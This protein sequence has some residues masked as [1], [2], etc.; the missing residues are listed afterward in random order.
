MRKNVVEQDRPMMAIRRM[1]YACWIP[2]AIDI[3]FGF[4]VIIAFL[5]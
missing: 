5:Q 1:R 2:N 4:E 3:H